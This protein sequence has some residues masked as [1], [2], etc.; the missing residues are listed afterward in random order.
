MFL[1]TTTSPL[2]RKPDSLKHN[3]WTATTFRQSSRL[4]LTANFETDRVQL[5]RS[6]TWPSPKSARNFQHNTLHV[7]PVPWKP[8]QKQ[9]ETHD[10]FLSCPSP[11]LKTCSSGGVC[12][13][14]WK[15]QKRTQHRKMFLSTFWSTST[16]PV[17]KSISSE[18]W[19]EKCQDLKPKNQEPKSD[20]I[21]T[22]FL[23]APPS[24]SKEQTRS[25]IVW[26]EKRTK[27]ISAWICSSV[28]LPSAV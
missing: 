1:S 25:L 3:I 19:L 4:H 10:M 13:E 28:P 26:C 27:A 21:P 8:I 12:P 11:S 22:R 5:L 16:P 23:S 2:N 9:G 14:N 7:R 15:T 18:K 24:P 20:D 6:E 17:Q